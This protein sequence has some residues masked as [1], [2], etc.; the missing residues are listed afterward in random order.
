MAD[1]CYLSPPIVS[2]IYSRLLI[3]VHQVGQPKALQ[4]AVRDWRRTPR[5]T[6]LGGLLAGTLRF[7]WPQLATAGT[8]P[9]PEEEQGFW[10]G[11]LQSAAAG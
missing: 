10:E 7:T 5:H 11:L 2:V 8:A 9:R 6:A 1:G 4:L 3:V